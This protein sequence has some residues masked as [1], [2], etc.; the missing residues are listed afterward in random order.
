M[1][2]HARL[3]GPIPDGADPD[4]YDR[5]RRRVLWKLT[6]GLYLLASRG[7]EQRNLMT[8]SLV[9]QL[10][11]DPKLVG[12]AVESDA[13]SLRLVREGRSFLLALLD[14]EDRAV[15]RSFAKPALDDPEAGTLN[16]VACRPSPVTGC[17]LPLRAAAYLD[18]RLEREVDVGSHVL[19]VGEVVDA[20]FGAAG[21]DVA[22][23][24]SEDTRMSY[25]G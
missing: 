14:R 17:P 5:V 22:L 3:V 2:P 1:A 11:T 23:L 8:C 13:L 7:R 21:P 12:V 19:C 18:C 9:T 24:R 20:G 25:G 6:T 16:G 10:A 15:V 4:E